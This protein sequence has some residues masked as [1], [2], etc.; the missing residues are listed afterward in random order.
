MALILPARYRRQPT[1]PVH[2]DWSHPLARGLAYFTIGNTG[3]DLVSYS[4]IERIGGGTIVHGAFGNA[5]KS[6]STTAD[7]WYTKFDKSKVQSITNAYTIA[8]HTELSSIAANGKIFSLPLTN[9]TWVA[10]YSTLGLGAVGSD[11]RVYIFNHPGAGAGGTLTRAQF[12]SSTLTAGTRH[13]I[14][15]RDGTAAE[16]LVNGTLSGVNTNTFTTNDVVFGTADSIVQF[17]RTVSSLAEGAIGQNYHAALWNR[18]L[19]LDEKKEFSDNPYGLLIP[20]RNALYSFVSATGIP[21]DSARAAAGAAAIPMQAASGASTFPNFIDPPSGWTVAGNGTVDLVDSPPSMTIHATG[22]GTTTSVRKQM[23]QPLTIGA[24]YRFS[25]KVA[26]NGVRIYLEKT[27]GG[28]N[29][30]LDGSLTVT[31]AGTFTFDFQATTTDLWVRFERFTAGDAVLSEFLLQQTDAAPAITGSGAATIPMQT[32]TGAATNGGAYAATGAAS[33][34]F[35]GATGAALF[36][37]SPRT[38]AGAVTIPMQ[39]VAG[40]SS[41][42]STRTASGAAAIPMQSTAAAV[43]T[44]YNSARV[45]NGS[46]QHFEWTPAAGTVTNRSLGFYGLVRFDITPAPTGSYYIAD[47]GNLVAGTGGTGRIRL[48]YDNAALQWVASSASVDGS[49]YREARSVAAP[50]AV[51]R[52]YFVGVSVSATGDLRIIV[53]KSKNA[54]TVGTIPAASTNVCNVFRIGTTARTIPSGRVT[55]A[56]GTWFMTLGF[57]PT[58]AQLDACAD[59]AYAPNVFTPT[60][61]WAMVETGATEGDRMGARTLQALNS[62]PLATTPFREAQGTATIPMQQSAGASVFIGSGAF[63]ISGSAAIPMQQAG[64]TAAAETEGVRGNWTIPMQRTG[65]EAS[66]TIPVYSATGAVTIPMLRARGSVGT[67]TEQTTTY[68]VS[69]ITNNS[70]SLSL[71]D[72]EVRVGLGCKLGD[73][74]LG[75]IVR[76]FVNGAAVTTQISR[77]RLWPDGSLKFGEASFLMPILAAGQAVNVEWR[78]TEGSWAAQDTGLHS[79]PTAI[80]N[81]LNAEWRAAS[82]V[83]RPAPSLLGT[84][85]GP[86]SFRLQDMLADTNAPWIRTVYAGHLV[87]EW[88]ASIFGRRPDGTFHPTFAAKVYVRAWGGTASQPK[89]IE[90]GFK[91]MYGWSDDSILA[92]ASGFR[93]NWDLLINGAVVRGTSLG[94]SGWTNV[95]GFK[96]GAHFSFGP[97]GKLDWFDVATQTRLDPPALVHKHRMEYLID[98][99]LLPPIDLANTF[100]NGAAKK[101][102]LYIPNTKGL[103]FENMSDVGERDDITWGLTGWTARTMIAHGQAVAIADTAAHQQTSRTQALAVAA[104][105]CQGYNRA[106][107]GIV[108]HMPAAR[109]PDARLSPTL[110]GSFPEVSNGTYTGFSTLDEAH[111]PNLAYF[112][113]LTAGDHHVLQLIYGEA[114][115]PATFTSPFF[116]K[117]TSVKLYDTP[118]EPTFPV[119]HQVIRGQI[120]GIARHVLQVGLAVGIGHPDDLD[121]IYYSRILEDWCTAS[122]QI[123]VEED[124]FRTGTAHQDNF[125]YRSANDPIYKGWMH[126]LVLHGLAATYGVTRRSDVLARAVWWS[127]FPKLALGG[128]N[129][130]N[131][132]DKRVQ[133]TLYVSDELYYTINFGDGNGT[134]KPFSIVKQW[135]NPIAVTY[136]TDGTITLPSTAANH[137]GAVYT[138]FNSATPVGLVR[139][140][141]YYAVQTAG[142]TNGRG[143]TLKVS[144]TIGGT[145]V[146]FAAA[147]PIAATAIYRSDPTIIAAPLSDG[148]NGGQSNGFGLQMIG[149]LKHYY[150]NAGPDQTAENAIKFIEPY[151]ITGGGGWVEKAKWAVLF[152]DTAPVLYQVYYNGDPVYNGA[153]EVWSTI[154]TG[155]YNGNFNIPMIQAGG[156][157]EIAPGLPGDT[158]GA[159]TIPMITFS[160]EVEAPEVDFEAGGNAVIPMQQIVGTLLGVAPGAAVTGGAVIPMVTLSGSAQFATLFGFGNA[161]MPM[162]QAGGTATF[163][164]P[165]ASLEGT[166]T[167]PMQSISGDLFIGGVP[168][169][170]EITI[171]MIQASG[172]ITSEQFAYQ[173]EGDFIVPMI[174]ATGEA[175]V[176]AFEMN[177]GATIPMQAVNG[178]IGFFIEGANLSGDFGIPMIQISTVIDNQELEVLATGDFLIPMVTAAGDLSAVA[179][180]DITGAVTIPMITAG[181]GSTPSWTEVP[182]TRAELWTTIVPT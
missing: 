60:A 78:K 85:Q 177:G 6:S 174:V 161:V 91:S 67:G 107:R 124:R 84:E 171:P 58:D 158:R 61:A 40:A 155:T 13:Y 119:A 57:V 28:T 34:P 180:R 54:A 129:G 168:V 148:L 92:D 83:N 76:A 133:S 47:F 75:W 71:E 101:N 123:P 29:D 134:R 153:D 160:G 151:K 146:V 182:R 165:V 24:N 144:Q 20:Q 64:G 74:P 131:E 88:E 82:W 63:L 51:G 113:Y 98:A 30:Y 138:P 112:D 169:H 86:L 35:Q 4:Q 95:N 23:S 12:G 143:G 163:A 72:Q 111:F 100:D 52:Y 38:A 9:S 120:R 19:S 43:S 77:R 21:G 14:I 110:V 53:D 81:N 102:T 18:S 1:G 80:I 50:L 115:A 89:R 122:A 39:T 68:Y 156:V 181:G 105:P 108:S 46:N 109:L 65:G 117:D 42:I 5:L 130:G 118:G 150:H 179:F 173:V 7:G 45:L 41:Q 15:S 147:S 178:V 137:D 125:I 176:D 37:A 79:G 25:V 167:I 17:N 116:G 162:Q 62:P 48:I 132:P 121:H 73:V 8:V 59:G 99:R 90:F 164:Q 127:N 22:T 2:I 154:P 16:A 166:A 55:G 49:Q 142:Q 126:T 3:A 32:V 96:G 66:N 44:R 136:N 26:T 141:K 56:I 106:T 135:G 149:A 172:E 10:P 11:G 175:F 140:E 103:C 33:I 94:T 27:N 69:T 97:T 159:V 145:P 157:I 152:D 104:I 31:N 170:G 139:G 36:V 93:A 70:T 114:G 87:T 128:Y